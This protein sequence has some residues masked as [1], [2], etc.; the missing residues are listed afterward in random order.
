MEQEAQPP[1]ATNNN[2]PLRAIAAQPR[3]PCVYPPKILDVEECVIPAPKIREVPLAGELPECPIKFREKLALSGM[4]LEF[5][6]QMNHFLQHVLEFASKQQATGPDMSFGKRLP[7]GF[8]G[9]ERRREKR[10]QTDVSAQIMLPTAQ[11]KCCVVDL[12]K[13]G[14][15]IRV[16]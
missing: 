6:R 4:S 9:V 14:A 2:H 1:S 11:V 3:S 13:T 7:T 10:E 12:S 15:R 8:C 16:A 5:C